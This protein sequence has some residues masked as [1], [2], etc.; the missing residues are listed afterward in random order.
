MFSNLPPLGLFQTQTLGG[1]YS[2]VSVIPEAPGVY[3]RTG[4]KCAI[5]SPYTIGRRS[6]THRTHDCRGLMLEQM[7]QPLS[8]LWDCD[9]AIGPGC[10]LHV[11]VNSVYL[12]PIARIDRHPRSTDRQEKPL[13][14]EGNRDDLR[15]ARALHAEKFQRVHG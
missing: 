12:A 1:V 9:P 7:P 13:A 3:R 14:M 2:G 6:G 4:A 10:S 15:R 11:L 5:G 8:A